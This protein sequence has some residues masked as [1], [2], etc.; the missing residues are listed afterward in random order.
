MFIS[1]KNQHREEILEGNA[2][3]LCAVDKG[4]A[5]YVFV[6]YNFCISYLTIHVLLL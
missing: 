1:E 2:K 4:I 3:E 6:L 5:I